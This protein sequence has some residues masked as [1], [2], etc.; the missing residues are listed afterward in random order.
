MEGT[1]PVSWEHELSSSLPPGIDEV[2]TGWTE[3]CCAGGPD[4]NDLPGVKSYARS[5]VT[6]VKKNY[7][8][9]GII[10]ILEDG[11]TELGSQEFEP[12]WNGFLR[13]FNLF[14][15]LPGV[16]FLTR[17]GLKDHE[18]D[19][20]SL[21]ASTVI[22]TSLTSDAIDLASTNKPESGQAD[23]SGDQ[24]WQEVR[25]LMVEEDLLPFIDALEK[26]GTDLPLVGEEFESNG[27]VI[28]DLELA[29]PAQR[30]GIFIS[31]DDEFKSNLENQG[32][33]LFSGEVAMLHPEDIINELIAD[34]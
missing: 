11:E 16:I 26:A 23:S 12:Q 17:E 31:I 19:D 1:I 32:W 9:V 27:A 29:W 8:Q 2:I 7:D 18:Y 15:F 30:I 3:T 13:A 24:A 6:C 10:S 21:E 22:G 4:W 33:K 5:L 25:E 20:L 34:K 14:Q 28:G